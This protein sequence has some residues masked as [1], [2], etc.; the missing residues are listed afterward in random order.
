MT[1]VRLQADTTSSVNSIA[2]LG[3]LESYKVRRIT[4]L[5]NDHSYLQWFVKC[6]TGTQEVKRKCIKEMGLV[7]QHLTLLGSIRND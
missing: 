1:E 7:L 3:S 6:D 2:E 5:Q 4:L